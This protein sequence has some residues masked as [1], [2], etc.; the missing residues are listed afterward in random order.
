MTQRLHD[1]N[2]S[3]CCCMF[4]LASFNI[5]QRGSFFGPCLFDRKWRCSS[6]CGSWHRCSWMQLEHVGTTF[7]LD[8]SF[9][10]ISIVTC[11]ILRH[12]PPTSRTQ[13]ILVTI[14][15]CSPTLRLGD[16]T[17][18]PSNLMVCFAYSKSES[19]WAQDLQHDLGACQG[20]CQVI[21]IIMFGSHSPCNF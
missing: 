3:T 20:C 19:Q 12:V 15:F 2:I 18:E 5:F 17:A 4:L 6:S 11:N 8:F 14:W 21:M 7:F 1:F 10:R 9:A 16:S 13:G